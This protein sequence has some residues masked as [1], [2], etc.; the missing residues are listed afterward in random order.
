MYKNILIATDGSDLAAKALANGL[1]LAKSVGA[2]T[3]VVTVIE[4]WSAFEIAQGGDGGLGE[5]IAA[6]QKW[7]VD[8]ANN[9]L[10][11]AAEKA[12][13]S[14]VPC[15][16]RSV[17]DRHPSDGILEVAKHAGCDLIIIGSHGRRG[18]DRLLL[19][20]VATEVLTHSKIPAL[21]VR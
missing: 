20:S 17:S 4:L 21:I 15:E 8:H 7:A 19:G 18:L 11:D 10:S 6:C 9:V 13:A 2:S 5:V 3:T 1:A 14:G 12:R 16:T